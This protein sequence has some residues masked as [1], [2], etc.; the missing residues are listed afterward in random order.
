M[1][2]QKPGVWFGP[3]CSV[4]VGEAL[5]LYHAIWWIHEFQ[6][7]NVDFEVDSKIVA[8]YFN[9][10]LGDITEFGSIMDS[11]I[12]L[13]NSY[14]TNSY[15]EFIRRQANEVAHELAKV[16]TSIRSFRISL[17]RFQHVLLI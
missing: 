7:I 10:G 3:L 16:A 9:K 5:G 4:E 14:L 1:S 15:V 8:D 17:M 12:Q 2:A 6:L 13:C 11:I